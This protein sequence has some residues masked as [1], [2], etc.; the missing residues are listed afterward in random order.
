LTPIT[1]GVDPSWSPD[2]RTLAF[3]VAGNGAIETCLATSCSAPAQLGSAT[4][5]E[6]VWSPDGTKIAYVNGAN[7]RVITYPGGADSLLVAGAAPSQ[8]EGGSQQHEDI[9]V[10]R[11]R[12]PEGQDL[13]EQGDRERNRREHRE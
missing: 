6:P 12:H 4:G 3:A 5:S 1:T 7:I 9:A 8:D 11:Q 2:G 13:G 10:G